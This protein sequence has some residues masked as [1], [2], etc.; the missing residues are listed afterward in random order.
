MHIILC[1]RWNR[2]GKDSILTHYGYDVSS[3]QVCSWAIPVCSADLHKGRLG[4]C[5]I[6]K[7]QRRWTVSVPV[8]RNF[9]VVHIVVYD[10]SLRGQRDSSFLLAPILGEL[11]FISMYLIC[12]ISCSELSF[13]LMRANIPKQSG[14][15]ANEAID[16]VCLYRHPHIYIY[17]YYGSDTNIT[18]LKRLT[19]PPKDSQVSEEVD[20]WPV[21][22]RIISML[23]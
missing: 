2:Y 17:T 5:Q 21:Y 9:L 1:S 23:E 15:S 16:V 12:V 13:N 3:L 10:L 20:S 19:P 22:T 8:H 7:S 18:L 14:L 6:C 4:T 11:V